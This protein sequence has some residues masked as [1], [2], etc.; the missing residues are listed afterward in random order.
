MFDEVVAELT[1]I[2]GAMPMGEGTNEDN[3]LG[4]LQNK[5]QYDIVARLVESARKAGGRVVLGGNPDSSKPGFFYPTTLV[6]DVPNDNPL[7]QVEQFGP[8]LPIVRYSNI[9]DA[10]AM[11]NG[12]DV[13]LGAS[14][15]SADRT[16]ALEIAARLEA[17]TVWINSHGGVNPMVPFGGAKQSGY[18]LE[19]GVEGLKALGLPQVINS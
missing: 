8:A 4:P 5:Q 10:I 13:G 19:F 3:V 17:G 2:A 1:T 18:G 15:W 6:A 16:K 11:A 7:V 12:V 9:E 14:V